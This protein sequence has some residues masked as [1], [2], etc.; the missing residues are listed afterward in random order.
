LAESHESPLEGYTC[1]TFRTWKSGMFKG[2]IGLVISRELNSL[3][4]VR[5]I[6]K[7][8]IAGIPS[9]FCIDILLP[10]FHLDWIFGGKINAWNRRVGI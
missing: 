2:S 3:V 5:S 4:N 1:G 6:V 9:Q 8:E 10:G 7:L